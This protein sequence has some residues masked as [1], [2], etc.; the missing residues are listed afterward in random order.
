[1]AKEFI[2][3]IQKGLNDFPHSSFVKYPTKIN[4]MKKRVVLWG[5]KV[6]NKKQLLKLLPTLAQQDFGLKDVIAL[7]LLATIFFNEKLSNE[8]M[9]QNVQ[10]IIKARRRSRHEPG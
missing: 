7:E 4:L 10:G 5:H 1:M 6:P 8:K 3:K 2:S 9:M